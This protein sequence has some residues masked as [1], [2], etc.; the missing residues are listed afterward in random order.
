MITRAN[1]LT[2]LK[3]AW[4]RAPAGPE[5]LAALLKYEGAQ[6]S[7]IARVEKSATIHLLITKSAGK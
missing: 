6:Q 4:E 1:Y 5:K 2:V 7:N 3:A